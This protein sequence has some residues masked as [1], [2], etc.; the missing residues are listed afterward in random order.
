M[1]G[2]AH[3]ATHK[4]NSA[5]A[6]TQKI[7]KLA[8]MIK[9]Y[10]HEIIFYGLEGSDV[11]CDAFV[12]VLS[13]KELFDAYGKYDMS[14]EFFKFDLSDALHRKFNDEC[15]KAINMRKQERDILLCPF[16]D[17]DIAA[18]TG[19]IAVESGVGYSGV[20]SKYKVFESYA[21]MHY[22][23]GLNRQDDG[24]WYDAVIPNYYDPAD[25]TFEPVKD[26]YLLYFGRIIYRKGLDIASQV[27][28]ATG[29][30][31]Y[32]IGQGSLDNDAEGLHLSGEKHIKY[33]P[34]VGPAERD[35]MI[36]HAKAVM[37]PTYYLEPFGGVNIE[38]QMCGT[39]VIT[40][41]WGAFP[42]TVLHGTTGY[43]CRT[44]EEF[45][46]SVDN[47]KNIKPEN[48][49]EWA[50]KNY[51]MERVGRMYEEYFQR[52][53]KLYD[54]GWYEE[55]PDRNQLEWLNKYYPNNH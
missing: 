43:R 27:A 38:A 8:R 17:R 10:G 42:E 54:K 30:T 55:N 12:Q 34:A 28:K 49:R 50:V 39:P 11:E 19:L 21:W 4:N 52:I 35:I 7:I 31:L 25:F 47:I 53:N 6:Y 9:S 22:V 13:E 26:D 37:M 3:V 16:G 23:Y 41:D 33:M 44:F 5:C 46:W 2:I 32:V 1:L 20:F 24:I 51:S 48:C 18:G 45:C 40:S 15:I 29:H 36:G 14:R